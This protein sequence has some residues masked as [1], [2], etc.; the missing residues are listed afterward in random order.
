MNVQSESTAVGA[1]RKRRAPA[2]YAIV[3]I[4][5]SAGA[6]ES[7][8]TIL[9][10]LP[11][12][13]TL[14]ILVVLHVH[15]KF[16]SHAAEILRRHTGLKVKDAE[17]GEAIHRGTV[18]M[19]PPDRHLLIVA[20]GVQL[21]DTPAVN[22]TRPAIDATFESVVKAYGWRVIGVVLS[23][24]GKDGS[25]GLHA[26]KEAGGFAI[27]EDPQTARFPAMPANA[28]AL[29][30]VDCVLP[31]SEI[32]PLLLRISVGRPGPSG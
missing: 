8:G 1:I 2:P 20:G 3:A 14:P 29:S 10:G 26:I 19:A 24:S 15:P 28:A 27:V 16:I 18:Y 12:D 31:L 23:G 17:A 4:G 11:A 32:A 30:A 7:L 9:R 13:F 6:L 25:Q 21:T 22:Y 5:G